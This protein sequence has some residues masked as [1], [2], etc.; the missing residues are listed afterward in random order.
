MKYTGI[1]I[2]P[3]VATLSMARRPREL[4]SA[5]YLFS[6]LM[7]CIKSCIPDDCRI[8]SPAKATGSEK[9]GVGL[10]PDRIFIEGEF[11][12]KAVEKESRQKFLKKTQLKSFGY[13]NMMSAQ[14]EAEKATDA[15]ATLNRMLDVAELDNMAKSDGDRDEILQ[16]IQTKYGSPLFE[17]EFGKKEFKIESLGEIAAFRKREHPKW[18]KFLSVLNSDICDTDPYEILK[19][20]YNSFEKYI[21]IVQADGDN[22]GKTFSCHALS[23]EN[24]EM[25]SDALLKFG[26]KASE[27]IRNFGGLPVYAGGDDLL[28]IA[29][30]VGKTGTGAEG[31]IFSLIEEIDGQCFRQVRDLVKGLGLTYKDKDGVHKQIIPSMSYGIS[32][33]YYKYPLYEALKEALN[34]LHTAKSVKGKNALAWKIIKHSGSEFSAALSREIPEFTEAFKDLIDKTTDGNTVSAVAHKMREFYSLVD[35]VMASG[36]SD[37][38]DSMFRNVFECTGSAY[39][40]AV[41][42]MMTVM[43]GHTGKDNFGTQMFNL[44]R[45]AKFIKGEDPNDD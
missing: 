9:C 38:L 26:T 31:T 16:L 7:D 45:T 8:V 41:K 3:I 42:K 35:V 15:I 28:F 11:D 22:M 13:F 27:H 5:S 33:T 24:L 43:Y 18:G 29:P 6:L 37:R 2:G 32:I 34:L 10:Y 21:C 4:W 1:T 44:L 30:V 23:D 19:P 14:C 20:D 36:N 17:I 12:I 39:F 25:V 40:E